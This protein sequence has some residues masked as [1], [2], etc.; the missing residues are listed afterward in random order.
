MYIEF[1]PMGEKVTIFVE[2]LVPVPVPKTY[3]Y[4]VPSDWNEFIIPGI[5][6]AVQFGYRK[7][8][9]GIVLSL[10]EE[11][12]VG[13]QAQYILEILDDKSIVTTKQLK[14]WHWIADYYMSYPGD[15]M[16]T[17]LP[18]G[19]RL[20]SETKIALHPDA[21]NQMYSITDLDP[22]EWDVLQFLVSKGIASLDEVRSKLEQKNVLKTI[23]SLYMRGLILM[24]EE[25]KE[26]YRPKFEEIV[27][28]NPEV[29]ENEASAN[30]AISAL[31]RRSMK[32][33][34]QMILLL[35]WNNKPIVLAEFLRHPSADRPTIKQ[36]EKKELLYIR[37]VPRDHLKLRRGDNRNYELTEEQFQAVIEIR[38]IFNEGKPALLEGVTGSGKTL[39]YL[40]FIR[41]VLNEGRQ[42]LYLLPEVALTEHVVDRISKWLG[43]EVGVWH[44]YYSSHERTE[45]YERVLSGD[46]KFVVGTRS[47]LFAPFVDLGLIVVDEE[48]ETSFK[49]FEKRPYFHARDAAFYLAQ[50]H[51][52]KLLLGSA[53]PSYEIQQLIKQ[54]KVG[55]VQLLRSYHNIP[56]PEIDLLNLS[57]LKKM[58][59]WDGF[60]SE[61]AKHAITEALTKQ[62]RVV[63]YHNRKGYVP[64]V[65]CDLCGVSVECAHCDIA[66]T[67]YKSSSNLRCGYCGFQQAIPEKCTA[68]GSHSLTLKGTGTEKI[69]EDLGIMFPTARIARFDQQSIKKRD[70][71]QKILLAFERGEIDILVGTQLLAKGI[72]IANIGLIVVPDADM[73][74]HI[75]DYRSH[76]RAFQQFQQLMGRIG[77]DGK[78]GKFML[79]THQPQHPVLQALIH[80]Q[81]NELM[82]EEMQQ[83]NQFDYP[84][85]RRLIRVEIRHADAETSY[86]AARFFTEILRKQINES[87]LGPQVP[88]VARVKNKFIQQILI[89]V[90]RNSK[91]IGAY[92]QLLWYAKDTLHAQSLWKSA[93]VDFLVDPYQ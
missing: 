2:V 16:A 34:N 62:Q 50:L 32:Q 30:A 5:R 59:A 87:V 75:P 48:H 41:E 51:G 60:L 66:L 22:K 10:S 26:N 9:A 93:I 33:F 40:E 3:T 88:P 77:R 44:H 37:K 80:Q 24:E 73:L 54:A 72:D 14:F 92:K 76:E 15:V 11:P 29:W 85:F 46:I 84:P 45:L 23:K 13:Y 86:N 69:A 4:R 18:S 27:E 64:Y 38:A 28:L 78:S 58:G 39:V 43:V 56:A 1:G 31:E 47:A 35:G 57:D 53:T 17:A 82:E 7:V 70:D 65:Q 42:V 67:Y 12:P 52:S 19:F 55:T 79:Q 63:V 83:R 21:D 61:P 89:K 81:Y 25:L 49:Q 20:Q 6:V 71:F 74:L 90:P 91:A 68:C 8:Y 36:L